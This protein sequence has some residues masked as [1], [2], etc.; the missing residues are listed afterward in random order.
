MLTVFRLSSLR[1]GNAYIAYTRA[2]RGWADWSEDEDK[3]NPQQ[4][5]SCI[6]SWWAVFSVF[7]SPPN[8]QRAAFL[9]LSGPQWTPTGSPSPKTKV[10]LYSHDGLYFLFCQWRPLQELAQYQHQFAAAAW[11]SSKVAETFTSSWLWVGP[12]SFSYAELSKRE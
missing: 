5:L 9:V 11:S 3:L 12:A 4:H 2:G 6:I 7:V 1:L 10:T 8:M